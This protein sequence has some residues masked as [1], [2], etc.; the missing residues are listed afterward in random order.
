MAGTVKREGWG[1]GFRPPTF[2]KKVCRVK[3]L[4]CPIPVP[5]AEPYALV[6]TKPPPPPHSQLKNILRGP[7][8][9]IGFVNI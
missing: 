3:D 9:V 5:L 1:G 2:L 8:I 4:A 7:C 6:L